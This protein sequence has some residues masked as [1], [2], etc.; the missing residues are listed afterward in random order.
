MSFP[1]LTFPIVVGFTGDKYWIK[2]VGL[3]SMVKL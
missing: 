2:K 1:K 3:T